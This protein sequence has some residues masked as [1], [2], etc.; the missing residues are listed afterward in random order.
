MS[1]ISKRLSELSP[2]RLALLVRQFRKEQPAAGTEGQWRVRPRRHTSDRLPLSFAQR[3]LWFIHQLAPDAPNYNVS[4]A[5]RLKGRLDADALA[6]SFSEIVR[7]HESL[8]A[9]FQTVGGEPAQYVAESVEMKLPV[10]DLRGLPGREAEARRLVDEEARRP[11]DLSAAPLLRARLLLLGEAEHVLLFTMHHIIS[12]GWST[13]VLVRELS[14]LYN[15]FSAGGNAALP[16]L[17]V[18]YGD[19]VEWQHEWPSGETLERQVSYWKKR[20]SGAPALLELPTDRPRPPVQGFDG[21]VHHFSIPGAL[22]DGLRRI[23]RREGATLFMTLLAAF[24]A[25]LC[26]WTGQRDL[27]VGTPVANRG[28]E[29]LEGLIGFFVNTLALRADLSGD[30]TFTHLLGRVREKTLD[31]YANQDV[32][33]ERLV[34]ELRPERS[35]SHNPVFQVMFILQNT[36]RE[37][38]TLRGLSASPATGEAQVSI[39]DLTLLL[40][41][42]AD[43][44][45]GAVQYSTDIFEPTTVERMAGHYVRLLESVVEGPSRRLSALEWLTE[46]ERVRLV[47]D[48]NDAPA[49]EPDDACAHD[50]FEAQ[51]RRRP[52]AAAVNFEGRRLSYAELD[53]RSNRLANY[54]RARGVGPDSL[55]GVCVERSAE[56]VVALLAVLKAGGAYVPLDPLYPKERLAYMLEDSWPR[57]LLTQSVLTS[58]LPAHSSEV[59]R[60][61]ADWS[62]TEQSSEQKPQSGVTADNL[63]YVI[64]TSGSTGRPKGVALAHRGLCNMWREQ[65]RAFGLTPSDRVLQFSSLSFDASTFEVVMAL[66]T[67]SALYVAPKEALLPGET[68]AGFVR[69]HSITNIV[70]PPSALTPTPENGLPELK[71]VVVAGEACT[72]E[73]VERWAPGR[74]F[75][76][77]YGPTETTIWASVDECAAGA[78]GQPTIGR[79]IGAA[80]IHILDESQ[81]LAPVGVAGELCIG[82]VGLARG[83]LGRPSLTAEKFIPDGY[84]SEPGARLYRT[85]DL[86]RRLADG[87]IEFIGRLDHQVKVRGFRIELGEIESALRGFEGV[88]EAV[89]VA[90]EDERGD[91]RLVAYVA[92]DADEGALRGHLRERLPEFMT[93]SAF[94]VMGEL[95]LTSNGKVDRKALPAPGSA[96]EG[97][98]A[99]PAPPRT[100]LERAI[101]GVWREVLGVETVGRNDNFF[102]L[103]GHSL[104]M[105]RAHSQL[106]ERLGRE[107]SVIDLFRY[108]TVGSLAE[109]MSGSGEEES[110]QTT[111]EQRRARAEGRKSLTARRQEMRVK[112]RAGDLGRA[113]AGAARGGDGDGER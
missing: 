61:D 38:F 109:R 12:D 111:H 86:A 42:R 30:P 105:I 22:A 101:A 100:E 41:E 59:F 75:F 83:Y 66:L 13:G 19:Y 68:L 31:A 14:S 46:A 32:P 48:F 51:A 39:F 107:T 26:K 72:S 103:G 3:R 85:G 7:R 18:Q 40:E 79:P 1:D 67:G 60:L 52:D 65:V 78:E 35:L 71:R 80:R 23:S 45:T 15:S 106:R 17:P 112:Y 76:N 36:P 34:E 54:L 27:V 62:L 96:R 55:V 6:R 93:P 81:R 74:R 63:A 10:T 2:E 69:E 50:L 104:L 9:S 43:G 95:P 33:F 44:L 94:V 98:Q 16:E 88:R 64:Y 56:M 5:V 92:G 110:E 77:A 102:D 90:R 47:K 11:F 53:A 49:V 108:P 70:V 57:V 82:G 99:P 97:A 29:E 21:A 113:T 28:Q 25:L 8:R 73:L 84:S 91:K 89:V 20:L 37:R 58:G 87:R 24:E 4:A